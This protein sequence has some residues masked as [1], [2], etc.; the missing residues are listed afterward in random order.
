M[1]CSTCARP[2]HPGRTP[3]SVCH[4]VLAG[5]TRSAP[6]WPLPGC[7]GSIWSTLD[8]TVHTYSLSPPFVP[9]AP[10]FH[11]LPLCICTPLPPIARCASACGAHPFIE[12]TQLCRGPGTCILQARAPCLLF[13]SS[14]PS[15]AAAAAAAPLATYSSAAQL[16]G[17]VTMSMIS[18]GWRRGWQKTRSEEGQGQKRAWCRGHV[19]AKFAAKCHDCMPF[20][21]W[22][23]L[24]FRRFWLPGRTSVPAYSSSAS[25]TQPS[26]QNR[27]CAAG[28]HGQAGPV[29][30]GQICSSDSSA[31]AG[32]SRA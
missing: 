27:N 22:L 16:R 32:S 21:E 4:T 30:R 20:A 23:H 8:C 19:N 29:R 28:R 31:A 6:S 26:R 7:G 2:Q 15:P 25:S 18:K 10:A 14:C 13:P 1:R 5:P 17:A 11:T 12:F 3:S 24:G 9:P